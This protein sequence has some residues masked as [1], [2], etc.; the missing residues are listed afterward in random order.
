MWEG[1]RWAPPRWTWRVGLKGVCARNGVAC[2]AHPSPRMRQPARQPGES[3]AGRRGS[4]RAYKRGTW[5]GGEA[6]G[7]QAAQRHVHTIPFVQPSPRAGTQ[8]GGKCGAGAA[9]KMGNRRVERIAA[10]QAPRANLILWRTITTPGYPSVSHVMAHHAYFLVT[11]VPYVA[12]SLL[13]LLLVRG[14]TV[15][16][17]R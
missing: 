16:C 14:E 6:A 10:P 3:G 12:S 5:R 2:P 17:Q 8:L 1:G 7:A 13:K 15:A 9:R 11:Y 4:F